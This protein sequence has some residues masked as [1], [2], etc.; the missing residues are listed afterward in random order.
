MM[1]ISDCPDGWEL[2]PEF[3]KCYYFIN[4]GTPWSEANQ[5]CMALDSKATLTSVQSQEENDY[6]Q[7]LFQ[8]FVW[9]GASDEAEE[10]VW[11]WVKLAFF[12]RWLLV[13]KLHSHFMDCIL[14]P[15][16]SFCSI[17]HKERWKKVSP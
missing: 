2:K 4:G 5:A 14:F 3:S 12:M 1:I 10:G 11:R 17:L 6:I 7:S 16:F 13:L 9:T 15:N 8:D